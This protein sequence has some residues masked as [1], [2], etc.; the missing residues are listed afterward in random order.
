MKRCHLCNKPLKSG[1][2][3]MCK[4]C[5]TNYSLAAFVRKNRDRLVSVSANSWVMGDSR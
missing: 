4:Y 5:A 1:K 3:G 2:K